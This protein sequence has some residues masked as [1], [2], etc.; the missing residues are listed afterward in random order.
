MIGQIWLFTSSMILKTLSLIHFVAAVA[1]AAPI[2]DTPEDGI[3]VL[4]IYNKHPLHLSTVHAM[5]NARWTPSDFSA[6]GD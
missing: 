1:V 5:D 2:T 3:L 4:P 6:E